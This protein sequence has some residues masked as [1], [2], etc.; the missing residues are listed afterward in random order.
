LG[1]ACC[2]AA[3]AYLQIPFWWTIGLFPVILLAAS[4]V[5]TGDWL[6]G[7]NAPA[8]WGKVAATL[9]VP[10][11]C[12][13]AATAVF[14][15]IEIPAVAVSRSV[16]ESGVMPET[17]PA[18]NAKRSL[19]VDALRALS[20]SPPANRAEPNEKTLSDGWQYATH[21]ERAWVA[22]NSPARKLALEAAQ[23][24]PGFF[25]FEG[26]INGIVPFSNWTEMSWLA[27]LL[28]DS[29]RKFE[30][31][32]RLD[33]ALSCYVAVA[34]LGSDAAR[35]DELAAMIGGGYAIEAFGSMRLWAAHPKQSTERIKQAIREFEQFERN[36]VPR[37][38][39]I[40]RSWQIDRLLLRRAIWGDSKRD[41]TVGFVN[42]KVE[43]TDAKHQTV[44]EM[45]W[46]RWLFPWEL[47]RL[48]RLI[49]AVFATHLSEAEA[50]ES[51]L[52]DQGFVTMTA[53]RVAAWDRGNAARR[54]Y[55]RTTLAP[56]DLVEFPFWRPGEYVNRLAM[57]RMNL[58]ALAIADFKR[59]HHHRP[60]TL[61]SLVPTYFPRLPVDPWTG[62]DFLYEPQGLPVDIFFEGGRLESGVPLLASAGMLD[63]RF[64]RRLTTRNGVSPLQIT[65][66]FGPEELPRIQGAPANF[67][68]P[69]VRLP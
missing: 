48:E 26:P 40:L 42:A 25:P 45:W 3:V 27:R 61:R 10:L 44:S 50:V 19:F 57:E 20:D 41:T 37:S 56:P 6:I 62:G 55:E 68:G 49:D 65:S 38:T 28:L 47:V 21:S 51:D 5:R 43:A 30:S 36:A 9:V 2:W 29:A 33:E 22:H 32:D 58:I 12:I 4:W 54:K 60:D 13:L 52:Q 17:G 34:R 15:V 66:R 16:L 14:R 67:P 69:A 31:E 53:E 39:Q 11:V 7:R 24:E 8:A 35:S 23:R 18:A 1:F 63:G 46:I 59:E 64:V